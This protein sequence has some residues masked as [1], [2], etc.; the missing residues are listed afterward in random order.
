MDE[1][2]ILSSFNDDI[3]LKGLRIFK[4]LKTDNFEILV[5]T[6]SGNN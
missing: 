1:I 2:T 4:V 3:V 5:P 6:K